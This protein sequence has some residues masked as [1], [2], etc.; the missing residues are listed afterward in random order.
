MPQNHKNIILVEDDAELAR[1]IIMFLDSEGFKVEHIAHGNDAV[2]KIN[3]ALADLIILDVMLPGKNGIEICK[4]IRDFYFG[5]ILML[6]ASEDEITQV[7]AM[8][9]GADTYLGKPVKPHILLAHI[10]SLLRR[11]NPANQ[12]E[13]TRLV[14]AG[15]LTI[16]VQR[17][18]VTLDGIQVDV[19][20]AEFDLLALLASKPGEVISR[21]ECYKKLR[22]INYDGEDRAMDVRV[23]ELRKKLK[24]H[25]EI[26]PIKTVRGTGYMLVL[27]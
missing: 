26:N 25:K 7:S 9:T 8:N 13:R 18:Q 20:T 16:D 19:T 2:G 6:T 21:E 15:G 27:Q 14:F 3:Q 22:G 1:L 10:N 24:E 12:K 17:R 5:P 23:V 4:E 11:I